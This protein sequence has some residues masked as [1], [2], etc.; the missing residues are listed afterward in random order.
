MLPNQV[1]VIGAGSWGT[2]LAVLLARNISNV[3]LWGR[4]TEAMDLLSRER[5]NERYLP[6]ISL[7][8]NLDVTSDLNSALNESHCYVVVVPSNV[9]RDSLQTLKHALQQ[10]AQ[11]S[12]Q[13]TLVWGTKG[14][15]R[16]SGKL[17]SEVAKEIFPSAM[18]GIVSGP[19][20]A[21]ETAR[22]LP[23]A[24]TLASHRSSDAEMLS[25]WFRTAN[26]RVYF[27]DDLVGVQLG[28]AVKNVMAIAA[29]ISDGLE[30]GAN[31]R[32]ALITRGLWE[33]T[34]LGVALGGKAETFMGLTGVGDLILTC[35]DDQSRNRRF[36]LG[37]GKGKTAS[38]VRKEIGQEIEGINTTKELYRI[39]R[40]H[41]VDMPITEQVFK[42]IYEDADP[43][44]AVQSLLQRNPKAESQ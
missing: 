11:S 10:S 20:F 12:L 26:T 13:P 23:T 42:I 3:C 4:N 17:L 41:N 35:T 33:L 38:I 1:T 16:D 28:G 9:F 25:S 7:P 2:A 18:H 19:S 31:A 21:L 6:G 30:Y 15:D 14:F 43:S 44:S 24:L 37:L 27:S 40:D 8:A 34:R 22:G 5:C 36:G 29:G 32:A 39:S